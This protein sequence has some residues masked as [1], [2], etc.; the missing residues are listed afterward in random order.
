[1]NL[2]KR[3]S[4]QRYSSLTRFNYGCW[5]WVTR[6][7]VWRIVSPYLS[8]RRKHL[9]KQRKISTSPFISFLLPYILLICQYL[10]YFSKSS[11]RMQ[12]PPERVHEKSLNQQWDEGEKVDH[13]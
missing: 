9:T 13:Y 3:L 12:R 5:Q 1:M 10:G 11:S 6:G 4:A 7:E 8:T 2:R